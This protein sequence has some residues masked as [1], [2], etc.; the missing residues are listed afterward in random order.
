MQEGYTNATTS[1]KIS[2]PDSETLEIDEAESEELALYEEECS[3]MSL[4]DEALMPL[5][6][7]VMYGT[8]LGDKKIS[9]SINKRAH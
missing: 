6:Y 3:D 9:R 5:N 1:S 2:S 7:K 8:A 4:P